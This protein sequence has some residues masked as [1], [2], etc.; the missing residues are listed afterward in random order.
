[1]ILLISTAVSILFHQ[2]LPL[3]LGQ[4][5]QQVLLRLS[6]LLLL[7]L[8]LRL[9]HEFLLLALLLILDILVIDDNVQVDAGHW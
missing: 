6:L 5:P 9:L 1:M 2:Q 3:L 7:L 8:V 4:L